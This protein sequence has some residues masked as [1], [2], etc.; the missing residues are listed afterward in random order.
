MKV[1][2]VDSQFDA[3]L[4]VYRANSKFDA[5]AWIYLVDSEYDAENELLW[6]VYVCNWNLTRVRYRVQSRF[7]EAKKVFFVDSPYGRKFWNVTNYLKD[8]DI[9]VWFAESKYDIKWQNEKKKA[10]LTK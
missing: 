9:T 1:Y 7:D 4:K 10:L 5:D 8:A 2:F 3:E 6:Y